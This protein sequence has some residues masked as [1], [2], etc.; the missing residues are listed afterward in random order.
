MQHVEED[1]RDDARFEEITGDEFVKLE[2][3]LL[4][5]FRFVSGCSRYLC[6]EDHI[7]HLLPEQLLLCVTCILSLLRL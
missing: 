3:P 7:L 2:A 1:D 4:I 6:F 5:L